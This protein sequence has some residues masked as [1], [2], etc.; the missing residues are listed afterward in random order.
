MFTYL[1]LLLI[2]FFLLAYKRK[3]TSNQINSDNNQ[4]PGQNVEEKLKELGIE[5]ETPSPPTA[6]YKRAIRTGNLI[7]LSGHGPDKSGGGQVTGTMGT[8]ELTLEEGQEAARLTGIA[9]LKSLKAEIGD[10]NKV[11]QVVKVMGMVNSDPSF[12]EHPRVINGFSDFM[13]ELFGE[14]GAHS[15]SA[16]GMGSL[17]GNITVE[18]EMIVEVED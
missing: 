6:N 3:D 4:N 14:K 8:G 2:P 16:V 18:I 10:L 5:L 12:T 17:P 9:L 7:Y 1:S 13:V 11:K 15:R